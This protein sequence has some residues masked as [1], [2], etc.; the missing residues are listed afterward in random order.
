MTWLLVERGN[1]MYR[2]YAPLFRST[3]DCL[4]R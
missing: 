4:A 1:R 2:D 3:C